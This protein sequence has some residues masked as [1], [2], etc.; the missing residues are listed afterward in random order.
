LSVVTPPVPRG[1]SDDRGER[2]Q[3]V[4]AAAGVASRR[5]A[6]ALI[7]EGRVSVDGEV[8]TQLGTRVDSHSAV[9]RVDGRPVRPKPLRYIALN[10]PSGFITTTSDERGRQTVMDLLPA[11][12][13]LFPVGRLD[14]DTEGLLLLTNDGEVANRVM[15]PRYELTKEYLVLTPVKPPPPVMKRIAAGVDVDG[16]RAVPHEFRIVRETAEG[17]LLSIVIHEGINRVVRKIMEGA[18]IPVTQLRRVRI[19]PL[20][21]AGIPRGGHRD[22]T[23]GELTS[24][25]Q[26][27]RINRDDAP[28]RGSRAARDRARADAPRDRPPRRSSAPTQQRSGA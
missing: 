6:E 28:P 5:K 26:A 3:R 1:T 16:K 12:L 27:L 17:V 13:R 2:L 25:L 10:K 21:V 9:V 15:H 8:V 7:R 11:G 23:A 4:L 20:S 18:G 14:R 19:G 22:L 24:L